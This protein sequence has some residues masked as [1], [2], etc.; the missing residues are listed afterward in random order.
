MQPEIA[1]SMKK[2]GRQI[3]LA[4]KKNQEIYEIIASPLLAESSAGEIGP[5]EMGERQHMGGGGFLKEKETDGLRGLISI[6]PYM[7]FGQV[8]TD[9][10][11]MKVRRPW[12]K[13]V[14][15]W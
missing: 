11:P 5:G 3:D 7:G 8:S 1:R 10:I 9:L 6:L 4:V 2:A 13:P 14:H 15:C 12:E